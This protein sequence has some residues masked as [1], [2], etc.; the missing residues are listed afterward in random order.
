MNFGTASTSQRRQPAPVLVLAALAVSIVMALALLWASEKLNLRSY[1]TPRQEQVGDLVW[2]IGSALLISL[3]V[4]IGVLWPTLVRPWVGR[5][6]LAL[7]AVFGLECWIPSFLPDAGVAC[8]GLFAGVLGLLSAS[9]FLTSTW[10]LKSFGLFT[11]TCAAVA[12]MG[13]LIVGVIWACLYLNSR[14]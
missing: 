7:V 13:A 10:Q 8:L 2:V 1:S 14:T 9:R 11:A 5:L 4:A 6:A 12:G 3:S